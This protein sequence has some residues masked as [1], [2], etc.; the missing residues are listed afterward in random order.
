MFLGATADVSVVLRTDNAEGYLEG[1]LENLRGQNCSREV[2]LLAVDCGSTDR[3]PLIFR[4][5]GL[6]ALHAARGS[7]Y[8]AQVLKAAEGDVLVFLDGDTLPIDND[9]LASLVTP[10]FEE[11]KTVFTYGRLVADATVPSLQRGLIGLR[12]HLSGRHRLNFGA[13]AAPGSGYLPSTNFALRRKALEE[14]GRSAPITRQTLDQWFGRGYLKVYLPTAPAVL[15]AEVPIEP[16]LDSLAVLASSAPRA[17]LCET[18]ALVRELYQLSADDTLTRGG[19]RG[20]AY[21]QAIRLHME[22]MVNH[23]GTVPGLLRK[24][25]GN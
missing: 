6:R 9:W 24:L 12:P 19:E 18:I 21:A 20:D 4:S 10:L 14:A 5:R 1:L 7:D 25:L 16:L 23:K 22:R 13:S 8:M 17:A 2:E 15:K 3:T 11:E